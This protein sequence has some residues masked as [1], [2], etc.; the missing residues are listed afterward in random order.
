MASNTFKQLTITNL[1]EPDPVTLAFS[2][3][4]DLSTGE[5]RKMSREEF[6][7]GLFEPRLVE[8]VPQEVRDVFEAGRGAMCYGYYFYPLF[9]MGF[10]H[11]CRAA[12]TA[13]DCKARILN[14]PARAKFYDRIEFL[15]KE[16]SLSV[17][18]RSQ[19]HAIRRLR[20]ESAHPKFRQLLPPGQ[21]LEGLFTI[22]DAVNELFLRRDSCANPQS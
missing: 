20:N 9:M 11:S 22:A 7:T 17:E 18:G 8:S 4:C 19:W 12:E 5:M 21:C 16:G 13:V 15:M 6:V 14:G 10:E 3:S 1:L 2:H